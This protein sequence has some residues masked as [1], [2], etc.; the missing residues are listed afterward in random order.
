MSSDC[1]RGQVGAKVCKSGLSG[2]GIVLEAAAV[3][4]DVDN[5]EMEAAFWGTM[6]GEQ[7]GPLRAE[8]GW[9]TVGSLDSTTYLTLQKVPEPKIG[10]NR[11]H[12]CFV[13][14]DVD[15]AVLQVLAIGGSRVSGSRSGGAVTMADPEGN[16][17]CLGAF[18]RSKTGERATLC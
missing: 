17:L 14:P 12:I 13:V 16:A 6:L 15:E 7:P 10:K 9:I 18:R 2:Y 11:C 1:S 3:V 8:G 5:I 4:L